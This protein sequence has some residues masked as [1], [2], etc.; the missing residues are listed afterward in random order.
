MDWQWIAHVAWRELLHVMAGFALVP[1]IQVCWFECRRAGLLPRLTGIAFAVVPMAAVLGL[2]AL[3]EPFDA[4][5][6]PAYKSVLDYGGWAAGMLAYIYFA[7]RYRSRN[8]WWASSVTKQVGPTFCRR[9][10]WYLDN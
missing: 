4:Q 10:G 2:V 3:R 8:Y 7:I 1:A 5:T 9:M 6:D